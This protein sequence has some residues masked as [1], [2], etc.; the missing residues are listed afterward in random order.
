MHARHIKPLYWHLAAL[1]ALFAA[2]LDCAAAAGARRRVVRFSV[3]RLPAPIAAGQ[4]EFLC[5][6]AGLDRPR[7][8]GL[9]E[10]HRRRPPRQRQYRPHRGV[11][12][13]AVRRPAFSARAHDQRDADRDLPGD[14]SGEQD[15]GFLRRRDRRRRGQGRPA[16]CR[17]RQRLHLPQA[18]GGEL[19]L[20]RQGCVRPRPVRHVERSDVAARRHRFD[21]GRFRRL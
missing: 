10:R 4:C 18:I 14:V 3:R 11:L 1:A 7:R 16:L 13:A 21:Q 12:R 8:A 20:Q 9:A 15:Q 2:M 5:R 6:A 17:S 19:H